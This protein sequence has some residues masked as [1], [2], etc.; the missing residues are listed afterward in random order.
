MV[1]IIVDKDAAV[2]IFTVHKC[3]IS[4]YSPFFKAAFDSNLI[5]GQTITM[6]VDDIS[7]PIFGL[8]VHWLYTQALEPP[9]TMLEVA[10]LHVL[11]DRFLVSNLPGELIKTMH[12]MPLHIIADTNAGNSLFA[13]QK[14]AYASNPES[15]RRN[16]LKKIALNK[17]LEMQLRE[18]NATEE[19]REMMR[20]MPESMLVDTV[21]GMIESST[22][23]QEGAAAKPGRGFLETRADNPI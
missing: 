22:L 11:A 5:E 6:T 9:F 21:E 8:F 16:P 7:A 3:L 13:F 20:V 4:Y 10:A 18:G 12:R 1:T 17:S 2:Q 23:V 19:K 14:F 15:W